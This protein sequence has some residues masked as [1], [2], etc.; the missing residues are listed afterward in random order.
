MQDSQ[1][2]RDRKKEKDKERGRERERE[3]GRESVSPLSPFLRRV[4]CLP[5]CHLL[6]PRVQGSGFRVQGSGFRV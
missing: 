3:R 5:H 1:R 6:T 4:A 2:E